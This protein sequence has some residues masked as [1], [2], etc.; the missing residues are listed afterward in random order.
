MKKILIYLSIALFAACAKLDIEPKT[1]VPSDQAITDATSLKTALNGTYSK[2]H[3]GSYYGGSFQILSYLLGDNVWWPGGSWEYFGK[4]HDHNITSDN[5]YIPGVFSSIYSTVNSA[6]F[7]IK[8]APVVEDPSLTN[9]SRNQILGEALFIRAL[10]YFDLSRL[11]GGVPLVSEPTLASTDNLTVP[12]STAAEVLN[13]VY[14]DLAHADT[15]LPA[16]T[17][18][19]KITRKTVWALRARLHLYRSEWALA[20]SFATK[21]INDNANYSLISPYN[22]FFANN[23]EGTKESILE[24]NYKA[25]DLSSFQGPWK[26]SSGSSGQLNPTPAVVTLLNDPAIGGNRSSLLKKTGSV[27]YIAF[28]YRSPATDPAFIIRTSE[29]YLIRAEA[30]AHLNDINGGRADLDAVRLRA[31]LGASTVSTVD[32]LLSAIENERRVEFP[33]EPH[34][35]FDLVRTG[36]ASAAL[37]I[38][39]PKKW[40]LPIPVDQV[41]EYLPQNDGY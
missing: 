14:N 21:I 7:V 5:T 23:V 20:D 37:G 3:S 1:K 32:E 36:R 9:A 25:D 24:L 41:D 2:L 8:N 13:F 10:S 35:W 19:N 26:I 18:R 31:G 4:I 34:R 29:L 16:T 11:W 6:N 40:I 17:V 28:Y 22:S 39:D 33:F 12:K 15:L 38:T 27:Y 30:R